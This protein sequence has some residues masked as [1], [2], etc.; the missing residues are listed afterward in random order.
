MSVAVVQNFEW[1]T[2]IVVGA[3]TVDLHW[4]GRFA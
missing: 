4:S 2:G 1:F 3:Q